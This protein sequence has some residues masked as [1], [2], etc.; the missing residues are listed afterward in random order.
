[1][2]VTTLLTL[3]EHYGY[4]SLFFCLWLGIV[5]I[6]IPDELIVMM[7]GMVA[8]LGL[9]H[10]VPAFFVTYFGVVSGLSL[11][12]ILGRA[13]G[14]PVL[15]KLQKKKNI[16]KYLTKSYSLIERYGSSSLCISYFFPIVRH[17]V[18]Y[19]VGIG[20][21]SYARYALFS[22]TTGFIWTLVFFSIGRFFGKNLE[23]IGETV[24]QYGLWAL[25]SVLV[26]SGLYW[27]T[28]RIKNRFA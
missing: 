19:L 5:G 10:P 1:M 27:L 9:L 22:Y 17:L 14:G 11:G 21:M 24:H 23:T 3:I 15:R 26:I 28:T 6:P 2:D 7:G 20:R 16:E 4:A 13:I 8:S 25:V 18:P 12:Y